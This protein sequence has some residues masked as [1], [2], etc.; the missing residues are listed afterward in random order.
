MTTL[1]ALCAVVAVEI[2][3]AGDLLLDVSHAPD[4]AVHT[5]FSKN[6]LFLDQL[7]AVVSRTSE[8]GAED[9]IGLILLGRREG[10]PVT[11]DAIDDLWVPWV[12]HRD[13]IQLF[14]E[15][16]DGTYLDFVDYIHITP[17]RCA[18]NGRRRSWCRGATGA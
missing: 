7:G 12:V 2:E 6:W 10:S 18:C 16:D 5:I 15:R 11:I 9:T 13:S 1:A 17:F 14:A 8:A 4:Y 3:A